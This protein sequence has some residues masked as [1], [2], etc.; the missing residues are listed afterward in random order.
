VLRHPGPGTTWVE[1]GARVVEW[2]AAVPEQGPGLV[3]IELSSSGPAGPWQTLAAGVPNDGRHQLIVPAGSASDDARLRLAL[4]AG[5]THT[6]QS[7][8][9]RILP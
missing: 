3:T 5:K 6:A 4:T 9:F 8:P 1:G 2:Q 7:G